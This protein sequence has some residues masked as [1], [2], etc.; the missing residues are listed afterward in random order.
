LGEAV[1]RA[2]V[3]GNVFTGTARIVN[4][5]KANVQIGNNTGD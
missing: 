5:S 4:Q 3:T 2:V 1:R